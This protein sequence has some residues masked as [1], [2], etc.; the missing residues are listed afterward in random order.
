MV[1][2]SLG[3]SKATTMYGFFFLCANKTSTMSRLFLCANRTSN[4]SGIFYVPTGHQPC[5]DFFLCANKT[6]IMSRP[7]YGNKY[8]FSEETSKRYSLLII[9]S[10]KK[11]LP[12]IL[13]KVHSV[14]H[15]GHTNFVWPA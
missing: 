4:M 15:P 3:I 5:L 12:I 1:G 2:L 6:S 7:F 9:A 13:F 10:S 11:T 14:P 8:R